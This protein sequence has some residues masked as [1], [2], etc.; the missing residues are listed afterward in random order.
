MIEDQGL[1]IQF[2]A[3]LR[4]PLSD[5]LKISSTHTSYPSHRVI[6]IDVLDE[7]YDPQSL[8]SY[9]AEIVALVPWLK[10][11]I[12]SRPLDDIEGNL[13]IAGYMIHIDLFT[14]DASKDI[15]RFTQSWF[16]PGGPL[17]QLWPQVTE[18]DIQA[19]AKRSYRLFIWIKT[20]LSYL[21]N[22]P[23]THAKLK[24][25]KSILSSRTVA[26]PEKELDQLYLRVLQSVARTSEH[27]Q[28]VVKNF[29][30]LIL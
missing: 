3:L 6:V 8:S 23:F 26:S 12:T 13:C 29:V 14:V 21:D 16:M 2:N 19:L 28:D 30:G 4:K 7:C 25:M 20:V 11:I 5:V 9:L 24:E 10:V 1:S 17:H 22:F 18:K 15:L 27:Y